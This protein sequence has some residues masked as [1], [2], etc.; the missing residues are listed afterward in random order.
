MRDLF[1]SG[2][3]C[4]RD[5]SSND[6][7]E[8]ISNVGSDVVVLDPERIVRRVEVGPVF[9]DEHAKA[10]ADAWCQMN[11][12][13]GWT[14]HWCTITPLK[15]SWMEFEMPASEPESDQSSF[16]THPA[17]FDCFLRTVR[18]VEVHS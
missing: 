10:V 2:R 5:A 8:N 12:S 16:S 11:K 13:H 17:L 15:M 18:R 6:S 14:G 4:F 7:F 1:V 9:G 3:A